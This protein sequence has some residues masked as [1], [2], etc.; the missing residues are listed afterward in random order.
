MLSR[1]SK[2]LAVRYRPQILSEFQGHEKVV[3]AIRLH[4]SQPN[5]PTAWMFSGDT[6]TGKTTLARILAVAVQCTHQLKFGDPCLE[7]RKRASQFDIVEINASDITGIEGIR[8]ATAGAAYMPTPPSRKRVFIL[9]EAQKLSDSSQNLL[10]K[11]FEDGPKTTLWII[12]TTDPRKVLRTL[13]RRCIQYN[14]AAFGT[15]QIEKLVREVM[16]AERKTGRLINLPQ[17]GA[18]EQF[19]SWLQE[20][21]VNTPGLVLPYLEKFL[22]SGDPDS[23]SESEGEMEV[24]RNLAPEVFHGNWKAV[25][26]IMQAVGPKEAIG[27]RIGIQAYLKVILSKTQMGSDA[28]KLAESIL[29][30]GKA[31]MYDESIASGQLMATLYKICKR[32]SGDRK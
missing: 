20:R 7:C 10:L 21:D 4:W 19:L 22:A 1:G 12:C 8:D 28:D 17:N 14:L 31:A 15:A 9:D 5:Q 26:V 23:V 2:A 32:F 6:G 11:P 16:E 13:R 30:L 3:K 29:D 25:R 18:V 24:A 27:L